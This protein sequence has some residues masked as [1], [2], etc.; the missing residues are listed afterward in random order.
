LSDVVQAQSDRRGD[1]PHIGFK[2]PL[3]LRTRIKL[4]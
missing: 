1:C 2:L 4:A 3:E